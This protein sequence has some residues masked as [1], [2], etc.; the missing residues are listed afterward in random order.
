MF[1]VGLL[2]GA[3][4]LFASAQVESQQPLSADSAYDFANVKQGTKVVHGFVIRNPGPVPAIVRGLEFSTPG[5]TAR[6][7]PVIAP[8]LDRTIAIEWDTSHVAGEIE[9]Q[10]IVH[11]VDTSQTPLILRLKGVV[12]P[13]IEIQPFPAIFLSAFQGE[14]NERRLKIVN[15]QEHQTVFSLSQ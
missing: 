13:P 11:F 4:C 5:M 7:S 14:N 1:R 3:L 9:A 6:F 2:I 10:A 12:Q 8:G 15:H